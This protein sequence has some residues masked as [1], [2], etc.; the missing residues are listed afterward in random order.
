MAEFNEEVN[1]NQPVFFDS[2]VGFDNR[3]TFWGSYGH[4]VFQEGV[5]IGDGEINLKREEIIFSGSEGAE[6][7]SIIEVGCG[8]QPELHVRGHTGIINVNNDRGENT[9]SLLSNFGIIT[10][11]HPDTI[12]LDGGFGEVTLGHPSTIH[13]DGGSGEVTLGGEGQDGDLLLKNLEG[14]TT[15]HLDGSN[16]NATLASITGNLSLKNQEG[17]TTIRLAASHRDLPYFLFFNPQ[18]KI[19]LDGSSGRVYASAFI[20]GVHLSPLLELPARSLELPDFKGSVMIMTQDGLRFC[21]KPYDKKVV[22]V[23]AGG[24]ESPDK[25]DILPDKQSS[26]RTPMPLALVG[27]T[28]CKV[29]AQYGS[30]EVGDLLT[31]SQTPGHAMKATD[32]S[33]AFGTVIGKALQP[34]KEGQGLILILVTLQ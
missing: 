4:V 8:P 15:I 16:G 23:I 25:P 17:E 14:E 1:F 19:Y 29:D 24:G 13:L 20:I 12:H 22:G 34:L 7:R 11:G 21:S 10:L 2:S 33:K 31:T 3:V 27:T 28:Y 30:I 6:S 26:K 18:T 9:I 5:R 32:P